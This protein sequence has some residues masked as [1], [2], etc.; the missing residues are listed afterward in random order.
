MKLF[1]ERGIYKG[2]SYLRIKNDKET[3]YRTSVSRELTKVSKE[4][5]SGIFTKLNEETFYYGEFEKTFKYSTDRILNLEKDSAKKIQEEL[6]RRIR[7]IRE[8]IEGIDYK[9]T[10]EINL[11][12]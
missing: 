2:N 5:S 4:S 6:N 7:E 12:D 11:E 10:L 3:I 8:W 1:I 9:E